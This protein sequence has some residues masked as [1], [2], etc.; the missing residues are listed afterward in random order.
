M[1]VID[2]I[3]QGKVKR[4]FRSRNKLSYPGAINHITQHAPG[5]EIL[6]AE[7]SDYLFMLHLMKTAAS[8]F[9]LRFFSFV[10]MPNHTHFL[11]QLRKD[12]LSSS[13]QYVFNKYAFYFNRKYER[14]GHVFC[15]RFRQALCFDESYLL[16]SSVYIHINPIVAGLTT[17]ISDYR[18]SS[19][20]PFMRRFDKMTFVDYRFILEILSK[21]TKEARD[22]YRQLMERSI[23]AKVKNFWDNPRAIEL[24]RNTLVTSLK[25]IL[26][27]KNR[28][29]SALLTDSQIEGIAQKKYHRSAETI[30]AR[31]YVIEQ[32]MAKG[33]KA[34]DIAEK[35]GLTRQAVYKILKTK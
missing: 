1:D 29:K 34:P 33:Y 28:F 30:A 18:W 17:N 22:M 23:E 9:N 13:L 19:V 15:G 3:R 2:L 5:K 25:E 6:F 24:F 7:D 10:L 16:A 27:F 8:K 31:K 26:S 32:L 20:L 14:K 21:D 4:Y 35:L 11:F 12:N